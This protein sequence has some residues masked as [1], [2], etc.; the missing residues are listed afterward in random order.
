MDPKRVSPVPGVRTHRRAIG[1]IQRQIHVQ[2]I[3]PSGR[4]LCDARGALPSHVSKLFLSR[5]PLAILRLPTREEC[6]NEL[7]EVLHGLKKRK[8]NLSPKFL[9]DEKGSRL[10]ESITRTKAYYPTSAET[11][12]LKNHA[13]EMAYLIG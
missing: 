13:A 6:M 2:S 11:E 7:H 9:Y 3:C 5:T 10:F 12:I 8:K 4:Q 1:R